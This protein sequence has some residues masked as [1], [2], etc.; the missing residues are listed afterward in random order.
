MLNVFLLFISEMCLLLFYIN[1]DAGSNDLYLVLVSVRD[2]IYNRPT[3]LAEF[4]KEHSHV[5][6]G[7]F[8]R[9]ILMFIS[10]AF[11][12]LKTIYT[13]ISLLLLMSKW[14]RL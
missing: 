6:G 8:F 2:E 13:I 12:V 9:I 1:P 14:S 11:V 4:W 3:Q 7:K 10:N 5:I